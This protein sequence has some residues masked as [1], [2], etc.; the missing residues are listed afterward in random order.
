M[1]IASDLKQSVLQAA[2]QGKLTKQLDSDGDAKELL[3]QIRAEKEKLIKEKKIKKNKTLL[4]IT[5]DEK[6]FEIPNNWEWVR[7]GDYAEKIT[8]YV[9]SGS[10]KSL[11]ENAPSLKTENYALL[12]KTADF[13]NNFTK[14]LTYTT[15]HGYNF[16]QNSNLFGGELILSNIGASI[17]K[18][19]IVPELNRKM[20]L[21][22]NSIMVRLT[23]NE[24]R[25]YLYHFLLSPT[26]YKELKTISDGTATKKFSK[27][28]LKTILIPVPPLAEQHRIVTR[29]NALMQEID[30]LEKTEKELEAIKAAFPAD[31]KA[32]LLQ[33]AMEGKLT[34]QEA[35]DGDARDLLREIRD[36]K[37]KLVKEKKIK[38]EKSLAPI[39][40][41]EIPF[42]IPD[43][44]VWCRLGEISTYASPKSKINAKKADKDTWMLDLEDIEKGGKLLAK[45]KVS[46]KKAIGDKTVFHSGDILYSKLRPYLLKILIAH[47][48]GI[49][50]PELIPFSMY[51]NIDTRYIVNFLKSP[52][53]DNTINAATYGLKMPRVGTNT[54]V[55]FPIPIPP[56]AEQRRIVEKLDKLL[57][58]CDNLSKY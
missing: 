30:K 44:W 40:D 32:S 20:T 56:L 18:I 42:D 55:N 35:E 16:L 2:I 31:M 26:G 38:K 10:F 12:V 5:E 50:T 45:I 17:G 37:E 25:D 24:L 11:R 41:D 48:D 29:I 36:E 43:N 47:D 4:P 13:S 21:A 46:D 53:V 49:C 3:I 39:T 9:A 54:M 19:F 27:T 6:P 34:R 7:F 23:N 58:L 22:P 52:Y 15:E 28:G 14:N 57:P 51:G 8:D 1:G 33:A